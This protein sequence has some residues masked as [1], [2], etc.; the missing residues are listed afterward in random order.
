MTCVPPKHLA[1]SK[2]HNVTTQK[3]TLFIVAA[4]R[5]SNP[6]LSNSTVMTPFQLRW[7][8]YNGKE[9]MIWKEVV[10][11]MVCLK[12]SSYKMRTLE[13]EMVTWLR[14]EVCTF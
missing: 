13:E 12:I 11:V 2:L 4:I 8:Y 14:Y 7:D 5:T 9:K 6:T 1:F 3:T 10:M